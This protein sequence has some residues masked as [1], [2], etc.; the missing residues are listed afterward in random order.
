[1]TDPMSTMIVM[2]EKLERKVFLPKPLYEMMPMM[3]LIIGAILI[4]CAFYFYSSPFFSWAILYFA[5][6]MVSCMFGVSLFV[7]RKTT[8]N[9]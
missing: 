7:H 6:G 9:R 2:K 3:L 8:R 1:M 4:A 5:S